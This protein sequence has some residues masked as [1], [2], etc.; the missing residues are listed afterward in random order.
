MNMFT[1]SS[2]RFLSVCIPIRPSID[3][4]TIIL[5]NIMGILISV[6]SVFVN[7]T[8][9]FVCFFSKNRYRYRLDIR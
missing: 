9:I 5:N 2:T 8:I 1:D 4:L 6:I 7:V 3:I